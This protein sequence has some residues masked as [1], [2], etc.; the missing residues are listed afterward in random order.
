MVIIALEQRLSSRD[1]PQLLMV[2]WS[3][4]NLKRGP[5]RNAGETDENSPDARVLER[6]IHAIAKE[7]GSPN[8]L[9][10][11]P[12]TLLSPGCKQAPR[13]AA[14]A[15][16]AFKSPLVVGSTRQQVPFAE[17]RLPLGSPFSPLGSPTSW[18]AGLLKA[19]SG[20]N[21]G[22]L[23]GQ[24][25][26]ASLY[27][28]STP[29]PP[30]PQPPTPLLPAPPA[31]PPAVVCVLGVAPRRDADGVT[32]YIVTLRGRGLQ[33]T[34]ARRYRDWHALHSSLPA[35]LNAPFPPK[36]FLSM[37]LRQALCLG[38][39]PVELPAAAAHDGEASTRAAALLLWA[40]ELVGAGSDEGDSLPPDVAAFL[41]VAPAPAEPPPQQPQ[42]L[43]PEAVPAARGRKLTGKSKPF[44][45]LK[46]EKPRSTAR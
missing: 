40:Q 15:S 21:L 16:N 7:N 36:G 23:T 26:C 11:T 3:I 9:L 25:L 35:K 44:W 19:A 12:K 43:Q 29:Q 24:A 22:P 14:N 41:E 8:A 34:V 33:W 2:R 10:G 32:R 4:H 37:G 17:V 38:C 39:G 18:S 45:E 30:T 31:E 13:S 28:A 20:L 5:A 27:A 42:L 46:V 1:S 6:A